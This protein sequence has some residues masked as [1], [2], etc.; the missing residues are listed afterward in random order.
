MTD[1]DEKDVLDRARTEVALLT[2]QYQ[3]RLKEAAELIAKADMLSR[4]LDGRSAEEVGREA[5]AKA[6]ERT[7]LLSPAA[8]RALTSSPN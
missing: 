1:D 3:R 4:G 5:F 8:P 2:R 6:G 7:G